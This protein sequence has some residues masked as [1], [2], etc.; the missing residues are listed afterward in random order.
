[1]Q[2][3]AC[4]YRCSVMTDSQSPHLKNGDKDDNCKVFERAKLDQENGGAQH[5]G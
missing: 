2:N 1:M 4:W 5:R 3:M